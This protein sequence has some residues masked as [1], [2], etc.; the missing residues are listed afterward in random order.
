M[1]LLASFLFAIL[2]FNKNLSVK[3]CFAEKRASTFVMDMARKA[4][5]RNLSKPVFKLVFRRRKGR[6]DFTTAFSGCYLPK[7][8]KPSTMKNLSTLCPL[9]RSLV[10]AFA[11]LMSRL[12]SLSRSRLVVFFVD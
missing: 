11:V 5:S 10:R 7:G 3:I 4:I 9:P 1:G 8:L 12:A 2:I 6:S